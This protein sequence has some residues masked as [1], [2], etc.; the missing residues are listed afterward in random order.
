MEFPKVK[1]LDDRVLIKP[2]E[3]VEKTKHGLYIPQ[4]SQKD[5]HQGIVVSIGDGLAHQNSDMMTLTMNNILSSVN[6]DPSK[7]TIVN[8]LIEKMNDLINAGIMKVSVGDKVVYGKF[9]GT[10]LEIDG[11]TYSVMRQSDIKLVL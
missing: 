7:S 9:S 8:G 6:I 5:M 3:K 11:V 2:D 4:T 1:L 10:D